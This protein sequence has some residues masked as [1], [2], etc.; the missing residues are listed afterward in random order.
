MD[1]SLL[2]ATLSRPSAQASVDV[3]AELA[4]DGC[5][6]VD[7]IPGRVYF[8]SRSATFPSCKDIEMISLVVLREPSAAQKFLAFPAATRAVALDRIARAVVACDWPSH[9]H[10]WRA[11]NPKRVSDAPISTFKVDARRTT[12]IGRSL[13]PSDVLA[14][15]LGGALIERF[16]SDALPWEADVRSPHTDL[17]VRA[18]LSQNELL[19]SLPAL[20]QR[21]GTRG[22]YI[23]RAGLHPSVAW[24]LARSL[25]IEPNDIVLDPMCGKAV[26]LCEAALGWPDAIFVGCDIDASQLTSASAN[27]AG[28]R[29]HSGTRARVELLARADVA[30]RCGIPLRAGSVDKLVA[31]LPFGKQFG[32]VEANQLLYPAALANFARVLRCGGRAVLLTSAENDSVMRAMLAP[33]HPARAASDADD[34]ADG[35]AA[36]PSNALGHCFTVTARVAFMLFSKMKAR[37]FVLTRTEAAAPSV[38]DAV[39]R[40]ARV[41]DALRLDAALQLERRAAREAASADSAAK[42]ETTDTLRTRLSTSSASMFVDKLRASNVLD[43]DEGGS[44]AEQW[45]ATRPALVPYARRRRAH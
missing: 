8:R 32:S 39:E 28:V 10:C 26:V 16:E 3:A 22:G 1:P 34:D 2:V 38:P 15:A 42:S 23:A 24:A 41:L 13:V 30:Q 18:R 33:V 36:A 6:I 7:T 19:V 27:V 14:R 35:A 20:V 40:S 29:S 4:A 45:K 5:E 44:W 11:L 17:I 9:L 12:K 25:E 43:W 31:D 37:I 21:L